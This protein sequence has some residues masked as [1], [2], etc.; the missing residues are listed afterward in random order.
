MF[1]YDPLSPAMVAD[2][3]PWYAELRQAGRVR[4]SERL[5]SWLVPGYDD[6]RTVLSDT[7]R[8]ASDWR[9]VGEDAPDAVLSMQ[10]LDL[11]ETGYV[12]RTAWLYATHGRNFVTTMLRLAAE[13]DRLDVVDDQRGQP[14][15][16]YRLAERL[17]A[18]A[19]AALAGDAAPGTYHG[20]AAGETTWC[21]LARAVFALRGLDPDRVRPTTSDRFPRPAPR[22]HYSVLA[23]GRWAAA[24]LPPPGHWHADL[25]E[26]LSGPRPGRPR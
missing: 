11:P 18:L 17:V 13:R 8:F 16:S 23:H 9:R 12:V 14:T 22:P 6:C 19:D 5:R 24:K 20:T 25:T 10:E 2:P 4:Y 1:D 15:W 3:Y 21:G 26:A 7:A